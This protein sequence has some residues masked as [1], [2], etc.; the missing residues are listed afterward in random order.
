M[1]IVARIDTKNNSVHCG[2][3]CHNN[4]GDADN[5]HR[6]I[7]RRA[8][9]DY[10]VPQL[11]T[12]CRKGQAGTYAEGR[13]RI[14]LQDTALCAGD[15]RFGCMGGQIQRPHRT[16]APVDLRPRGNIRI[17]C[18]YQQ[19][20]AP[21]FCY[22]DHQNGCASLGALLPLLLGRRKA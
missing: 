16:A 17:L 12:A 15:G 9:R 4:F 21:E 13:P 11:Y 6:P 18:P 22:D 7:Q 10:R 2:V 14:L 3:H 20:G 19:G 1:Y 8:Q 5:A